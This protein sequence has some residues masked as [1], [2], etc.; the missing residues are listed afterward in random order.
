MAERKKPCRGYQVLNIPITPVVS[1]VFAEQFHNISLLLLKQQ[2]I[3]LSN[4]QWKKAKLPKKGHRSMRIVKQAWFDQQLCQ[5]FHPG[6]L[7]EL[8]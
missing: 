2:V 6:A 7:I 3:R 4:S 1:E 8:R 5:K